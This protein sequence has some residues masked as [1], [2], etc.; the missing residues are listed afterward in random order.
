MANL[1][2]PMPGKVMAI[3]V[4]VGD[5]VEVEDELIILEALKMETP[6]YAEDAGTVAAIKVKEGEAVKVGDVLVVIE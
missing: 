4:A 3:K 5:K 1:T 6:I 2:S